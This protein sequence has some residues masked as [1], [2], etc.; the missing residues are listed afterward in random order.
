MSSWLSTTTQK[1]KESVG[2][3]KRSHDPDVDACVSKLQ[4]LEKDVLL[5]RKTLE[6]S[7]LAVTSHVPRARVQMTEVMMR[8]GENFVAESPHY[9][10]FKE[11]HLNLDGSVA[12]KLSEIFAKV[13]L[14]PLDEWIATFSEVR[15][16]TTEMESVRVSY[17]HYKDKL[18]A[19][20]E[21]K[22]AILLKGKVFDKSSEEK[23][24][25]NA[26]KLKEVS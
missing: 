16:C 8:M 23:L 1:V 25:R 12:N 4:G 13:V 24:E 22:R 19:L 21:G 2:V 11:A 10:S 15:T 5:L 7:S 17:D 3:A 9:S 20:Q 18:V 6:T 14:E 26:L